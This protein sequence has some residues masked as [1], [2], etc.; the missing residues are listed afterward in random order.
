[1]IVLF[2]FSFFL[3]RKKTQE[4]MSSGIS[5]NLKNYRLSIIWM[6]IS[7]KIHWSYCCYSLWSSEKKDNIGFKSNSILYCR[8]QKKRSMPKWNWNWKTLLFGWRS[9][10]LDWWLSW[11]FLVLISFFFLVVRTF[12]F[13]VAKSSSHN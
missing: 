1:M 12:H 2:Q 10:I 8:S 11:D 3:I 7:N 9:F 6:K 5:K 13:K 4:K